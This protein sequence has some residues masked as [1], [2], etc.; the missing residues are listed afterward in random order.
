MAKFLDTLNS[1]EREYMKIAL[2][3]AIEKTFEMSGNP[4]TTMMD[5][6]TTWLRHLLPVEEQ[7]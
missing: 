2:I 5:Q 6:W 4:H 1:A 7:E 3:R